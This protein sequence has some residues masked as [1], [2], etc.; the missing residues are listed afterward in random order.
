MKG[1][2]CAKDLIVRQESEQKEEMQPSFNWGRKQDWHQGGCVISIT[3]L[4]ISRSVQFQIR[5]NNYG[6]ETSGG[7]FT[8]KR[9]GAIN[10]MVHTWNPDS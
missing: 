6:G 8:R 9:L 10:E 3:L 2:D 7:K 5:R 1:K 4:L